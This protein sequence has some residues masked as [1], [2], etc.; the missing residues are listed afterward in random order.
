MMLF[1]QILQTTTRMNYRV[2]D[3]AKVSFEL[4]LRLMAY[5]VQI[6]WTHSKNKNV[7]VYLQRLCIFGREGGNGGKDKLRRVVALHKLH[8]SA[9]TTESKKKDLVNLMI[10]YCLCT[11]HI[12]TVSLTWGADEIPPGS[13]GIGSRRGLRSGILWPPGC[14]IL[15]TRQEGKFY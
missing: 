2:A 12:T 6:C 11:Q 4:K 3:A 14:S 7:I 10:L 1:E 13:R 9:K 5:N 15:C 8:T